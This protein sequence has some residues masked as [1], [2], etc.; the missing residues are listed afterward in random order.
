MTSITATHRLLLRHIQPEDAA[1]YSQLVNE[2][3]WIANIGDRQI[4]CLADAKLQIQNKLMA[5]YEQHGFGMYLVVLHTTGEPI[6]ICGLVKRDDLPAPDI[7]FAFLQA[8][9]A[10]GY[11]LEAA[12]AVLHHAFNELGLTCILGIVQPTN[13]RSVQL[14]V[15]LGLKFQGQVQIGDALRDLYQLEA[16]S[17]LG[18]DKLTIPK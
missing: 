14:L 11:A 6:G 1:F 15:K 4:H 2:P 9:C 10:K 7:G 3:A 13:Q 18:F 12:Q 8:H 17:K 16:N 5:A